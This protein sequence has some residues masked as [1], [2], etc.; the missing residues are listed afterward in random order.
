[1]DLEVKLY[2]FNSYMYLL[3]FSKFIH[4]KLT[5]KKQDKESP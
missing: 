3:R 4:K 1:M 2:K 5:F